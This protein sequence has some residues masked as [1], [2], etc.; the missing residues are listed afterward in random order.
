MNEA[1]GAP[2]PVKE[3]AQRAPERSAP[4]ASGAG[5]LRH[6]KAAR[7][8]WIR[9]RSSGP[10]LASSDRAHR[11]DPR[12]GRS[13]ARTRSTGPRRRPTNR[14]QSP[15]TN[16]PAALGPFPDGLRIGSPRSFPVAL[17]RLRSPRGTPFQIRRLATPKGTERTDRNGESSRGWLADSPR[18]TDRNGVSRFRLC[19]RRRTTAGREPDRGPRIGRLRAS[20]PLAAAAVCPDRGALRR[21]DRAERAM[22]WLPTRRSRVLPKSFRRN[23]GTGNPV[24]GRVREFPVHRSRRIAQSPHSFS[25]GL[26]TIGGAGAAAAAQFTSP[27]GGR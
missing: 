14:L 27:P 8:I 1:S 15:S 10:D 6:E 23:G 16:R 7:P 20:Q 12:E 3:P 25:T 2:G 9:S 18:Q 24:I 13:R 11:P 22:R 26:S 4:D 19:R 17:A 21:L 5:G